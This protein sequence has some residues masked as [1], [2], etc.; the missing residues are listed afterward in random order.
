MELI[1]GKVSNGR[2]SEITHLCMTK[3]KLINEINI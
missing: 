1:L 3:K 2:K